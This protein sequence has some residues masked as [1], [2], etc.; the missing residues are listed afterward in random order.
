MT[1]HF[2]NALAVI[3]LSVTATAGENRYLGAIVVSGSSLNNTTT[4]A[5]FVIPGGAKITVVCSAAVNMLVDN[6]ST[7]TTGATKGLPIPA[8]SIFPTSVGK[9][10]TTISGA[11]TA[12]VDVI[13]T[14]TCDVWQRDGN[15]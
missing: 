12:L 5:P 9:T 14:A 3:L 13:G 15:E 2:R 10:L 8:N 1:R 7:A 11:P 6:L 4:A